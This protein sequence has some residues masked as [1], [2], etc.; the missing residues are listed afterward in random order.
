MGGGGSSGDTK[1]L[2]KMFFQSSE[3]FGNLKFQE[4]LVFGQ[5]PI[6]SN[7]LLVRHIYFSKIQQITFAMRQV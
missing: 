5:E 7:R 2:I 4:V 1:N 3:K 6:T